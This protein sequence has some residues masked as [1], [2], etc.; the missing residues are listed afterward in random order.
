[1]SEKT[2]GSPLT[3]QQPL[4]LTHILV[5]SWCMGSALQGKGVGFKFGG[6]AFTHLKSALHCTMPRVQCRLHF[7][8]YASV[9]G[10]RLLARPYA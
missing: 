8:P 10:T 9:N 1:M 3:G 6:A 7:T 2:A 4:G 5:G